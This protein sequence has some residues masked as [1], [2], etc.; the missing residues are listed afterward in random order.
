MSDEQSQL[1]L[2]AH[3]LQRVGAF[4]IAALAN[5][6][7]PDQVTG[8]TFERVMDKVTHDAIEAAL[9]RDTKRP[10]GF[11]LKCSMSFFPNSKMNH[12]SN[13]K[14]DP[15]VIREAVKLW[16]QR[17]K[18]ESWLTVGCVLCGRPAVGFFGKV[19][20][21]LAESDIY[22]NTTPRGHK[23]T[24]LCWPCVCSFYALPY[25]CR[26][27]GGPSIAVHSWDDR[28]LAKTI[29]V[30]ARQNAQLVEI[31]GAPERTSGD[32]E[33]VALDA[34]RRYEERMRAGVELLVFSNNNRDPFLDRYQV[35]QPLAEW[36]RKAARQRRAFA[37]LTRAHQGEKTP[38]RVNLARNA[39]RE[40]QW[41]LARC[42]SFLVGSAA[43]RGHVAA[44]TV[45]L[46]P[47]AY[48]FAREVMLMDEQDLA[49]IK[50]TAARI[51]RVLSSAETG[52][53]LREFCVKSR[54]HKTLRMWLQQHAVEWAL[55]P[56]DASAGPLITTR[57]F[58]LLFAPGPD[59]LGWYY[60]QVLLIAVVEEL[61]R[62]GWRPVDG[63]Q[64]KKAM[65]EDGDFDTPGDD[66]EEEDE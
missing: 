27:T 23:G 56:P 10:D 13:G 55:T 54:R 60:R 31:G 66:L 28:F 61:H 2:T 40:P 26:L 35:D 59:S 4:A 53:K 5:V 24:A 52:G 18:P 17:P 57:G 20:V 58:D 47:L 63:E 19:D 32:R 1:V 42:A 16:R 41:I 38:G 65:A 49:E 12:P 14:K 45:D 33:L 46:A 9:V 39:F 51:A 3:P 48:S 50:A 11:W 15:E 21:P 62:L 43:E 36:L 22:R 34:L 44:E 8:E 37:A 7:H 29:T 6:D 25:G 30:Q 64:V